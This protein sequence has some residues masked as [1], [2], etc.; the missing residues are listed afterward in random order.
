MTRILIFTDDSV[1]ASGACYL[2]RQDTDLEVD[3]VCTEAAILPS[4]VVERKPDI[5]LLDVSPDI[6]LALLSHIRKNSP[7]CRIVLWAR[8]VPHE[9]AY[10]AMELGVRGILHRRLPGSQ[11]I[12]CLRKVA[13]NDVW[14]DEITTSGFFNRTVTLTPREGQLITLLAQG[15][16][17][18]EIAYLLSL[19]EGTVKV[20]MSRLFDKVGVKDRFE[21][22]LY[23]LRNLTADQTAPSIRVRLD[24]SKPLESPIRFRQ[25]IAQAER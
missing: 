5:L 24:D 19:S 13:R 22:A 15:L 20:Y 9:L 2:L 10:Q 21:L 11:L 6:H 3:S 23:G 25:S 16:R 7:D 18:K 14:F 8:D 1:L 12:H 17:N 4:A